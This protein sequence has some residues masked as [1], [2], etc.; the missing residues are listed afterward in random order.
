MTVITAH[1]ALSD[2]KNIFNELL[3]PLFDGG[4][5]T[6]GDN[7]ILFPQATI[8]YNIDEAKKDRGLCITFVTRAQSSSRQ[9]KCKINDEHGYQIR[10][11]AAIDIFV[12]CHFSEIRKP[13]E[14]KQQVDEAW[15]RLFI[16]IETGRAELQSKGVFNASLD[17]IPMEDI[18]DESYYQLFGSVE[19]ELRAK[20]QRYNT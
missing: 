2:L 20:F 5:H 19:C 8:Y 14:T 17:F 4:T 12:T 10:S 13:L 1:N 15:S 6:L 3:E 16:A 7:A 18:E 9:L 11:G